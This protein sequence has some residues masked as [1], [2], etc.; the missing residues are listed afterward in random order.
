MCAHL[1]VDDT[2]DHLLQSA[3]REDSL[4][5]LHHE[6][7]DAVTIPVPNIL[8]VDQGLVNE[9]DAVSVR[10]LQLLDGETCL[11]VATRRIAD[12]AQLTMMRHLESGFLVCHGGDHPQNGA[13]RLRLGGS[14]PHPVQGHHRLRAL[15][16]MLHQAGRWTMTQWPTRSL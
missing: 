6:M 11:G 8:T 3:L 10:G 4:R 7:L 14:L 2:V 1:L 12:T 13:R 5:G 16:K 9:T 15:W